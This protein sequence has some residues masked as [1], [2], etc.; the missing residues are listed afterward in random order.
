MGS[1]V[2]LKGSWALSRSTLD[3]AED[4]KVRIGRGEPLPL[5][6]HDCHDGTNLV[7][8]LPWDLV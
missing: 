7:G 8:R 6:L 1:I 2:S 4:M 3:A 5:G